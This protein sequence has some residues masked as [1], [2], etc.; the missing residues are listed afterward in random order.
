[1]KK[2]LLFLIIS[3]SFFLKAQQKTDSLSI[4][5]QHVTKDTKFGL[6]LSGGGA[7]GFAH[8]GILKMIDSL[9]IKIDYITGTSMGGILGGLYAMGYKADELKQTVYKVHWNRILSNK[10][11]YNKV[12]ISEKDEYDKYIL[13]F[14]VVKGIPT[15]PSSYIE[16]QYMGEVLNTLTFNAKHI[17]DFS[18]LRIPVEL[19]SS[20]IENGGLVMQKKG[21]LPLAIR[22]TLAIPA[23]FSPVYIDGKLLVDGGLDRNYPANEV[24]EMGADFVLGGYT[25]FRLFTKKEI[26][27]PM[28]MIYQTHAIRSVEDFKQQKALSNILVDFVNPLGDITTKDFAKYDEIIKIGE[29]EARKH[30]PEFIALAETQRK[31]GITYEHKMIEEVKMPTVKF[32]Y[33]EEDGTP[34]TDNNEIMII[35][36]MM[37]LKEGN[38]YDVKTVNEAIDRV[39]GMRHYEKVY[40]TYTNIGDGLVMNI[41]VKRTKKGAFKLALHYDNEQS[42]G[43]IVNYTYRDFVFNKSRLLATVD[44]S[45]RFKSRIDYQKFFDNGHRWWLNAEAKMVYQRSNDL[46]FRIYDTDSNDDNIKFPNYMYR[47]ITGK[48][49]LNYN[50]HPNAFISFGTEFSAERM[51]RYLD[52]ID[53]SKVDNYNKKLYSH[54]NFNTFLKIEQNNLNKRYFSTK[55]NHLQVSTRFYFG[56]HYNL[57]DLAKVQPELYNLL[58][59]EDDMYYKPKNLISFTLN[60]NFSHPITKRLAVKANVFL[61]TSFA[62]KSGVGFPYLFLN[63]K[64]N[65]GGSE[66][67]YDLMDP[68]FNGFRQREFPVSSVAKGGISLQ[69]RIM[70]KLYLT[71]SLQYA[72]LSDELSPFKD[73]VSMLGYGLNLG[74]ESLLGPI[75]INVSKNELIDFWRVYFSI[76]FKF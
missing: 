55:G 7:K 50:F 4:A 8:L 31:L 19:T 43:I 57:Y 1:M 35:K 13:E 68:E 40:Y 54:S 41:F 75:N 56:D 52:K 20:D 3:F 23:A 32:T 36:K 16:G 64:Y 9:G 45:E 37:N 51:N 30:L 10:I 5:L 48:V 25:G 2:L 61:G 76:G 63:Q 34:L 46:L 15:L 12:N 66:Y 69:Y 27:N 33:S 29:K 38:Y 58:N 11:P 53:Q 59:P 6:A 39:F 44:I 72:Q 24:R 73:N 21:S 65:L 22:S 14:P 28:K 62:K 74:Y 17:N 42:V 60:E 67:N 47:N 71:P 49:A 26:E 18:Q 70:K